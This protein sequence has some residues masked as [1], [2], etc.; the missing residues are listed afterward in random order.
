MLA[1]LTQKHIPNRGNH[2]C[3]RQACQTNGGEDDFVGGSGGVDDCCGGSRVNESLLVQFEAHS[4]KLCPDPPDMMN[5][6]MR[7]T[8]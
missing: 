8:Y 3:R 6:Y 7:F 1:G 2:Q 5:H 4:Q